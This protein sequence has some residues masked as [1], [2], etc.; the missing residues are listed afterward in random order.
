MQN[1]LDG[2][3]GSRILSDKF[4]AISHPQANQAM[5]SMIISSISKT[6]KRMSVALLEK[7][8]QNYG[9]ALWQTIL[10]IQ[11]TGDLLVVRIEKISDQLRDLKCE[12][13]LP[14]YESLYLE[15]LTVR[16]IYDNLQ[17]T[18]IATVPKGKMG[19]RSKFTFVLSTHY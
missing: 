15:F 17:T 19:G 9:Y 13:G 6:S 5:K 10:R 11:K 12:P 1:K 14:K 16:Y 7:G 2:C 3:G 18:S 8:R 4:Y